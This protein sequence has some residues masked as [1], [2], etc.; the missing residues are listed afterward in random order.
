VKRDQRIPAMGLGE[1]APQIDKVIHREDAKDAEKTPHE[2]LFV[3]W[4]LSGKTLPHLSKIDRMKMSRRA[5]AAA[6]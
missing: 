4:R 1:A 6:G 5:C 3:S 2:A